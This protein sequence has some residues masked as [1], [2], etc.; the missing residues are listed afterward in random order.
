[1]RHMNA[2]LDMISNDINT[3]G[4]S[5]LAGLNLLSHFLEKKK[6]EY[7]NENKQGGEGNQPL[8]NQCL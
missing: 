7:E 6:N 5:Y 2:L 4:V 1:M 3:G 8:K